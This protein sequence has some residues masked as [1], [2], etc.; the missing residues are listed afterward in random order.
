M[1]AIS[2]ESDGAPDERNTVAL[3]E[4]QL[5]LVREFLLIVSIACGAVAA[6]EL[7]RASQPLPAVTMTLVAF[8]ALLISHRKSPPPKLLL[9]VLLALVLVFTRASIGRG[10]AAASALSLAFLP[11]F[12]GTLVLGPALG[13]LI[14]GAMLLSFAWLGSTTPLESLF[15]RLRF[16][17]E[18]AMTIFAAGLAH[19]LLHSFR[20]YDRAIE[21][22]K[23]ALA[24]LREERHGLTV[25]IYDEL[26][27]ASQ[28]LVRASSD[29]PPGSTSATFDTALARLI[30]SLGR[31]KVLAHPDGTDRSGASDP[32]L[33][34]RLS[35]I[36]VWL[37]LGALLMAFFAVR[38]ALSG[39][40][41][42]PPLTSLCFCVLT[43]FWL[44]SQHAPRN[45][46]ATAFGIG[47]LALGPL[48][49]QVQAY[50]A[51]PSAP[52][53]VIMPGAVLLVVL[54]S[55][56]PAAFVAVAMNGLIL[57]WVGLG[58]PL[59]L[60]EERLLTNL[61]LS[62]VVIFLVVRRVLV[63]RTHYAHTLLTQEASLRRELAQHRR[64]AGTLFHDASNHLQAIALSLDSPA[65]GT[66][67]ERIRSLT[68]R[69]ARLIGLSKHFLLEPGQEP[70]LSAFSLKDAFDLVR[71]AFEPHLESKHIRLTIDGD[72]DTTGDSPPLAW[73][74]PELFVES[75]LGN[76]VS[77]AIKFSP[78][79]TIVAVSADEV[80]DE[81]RVRIRDSGP[82]LPPDV[83]A[84]FASEGSL[85]TRRGTAGESGQGYGLKLAREHVERMGGTLE[86]LS[87]SDG[88]ECVVRLRSARNTNAPMAS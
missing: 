70:R 48:I 16:S 33:A 74:E 14:C 78:E 59:S 20:A 28:E 22:R 83:L 50:G 38:N 75:V 51:T 37:W 68:K 56:G 84:H 66:S 71:E 52:A 6:R 43:D 9:P 57:L 45:L 19:T 12:L 2:G 67:S 77:N 80:G 88:T 55:R 15:D 17:D 54:L 8:A 79:G 81:I 65:T 41:F 31:A 3:E 42:V 63:L 21:A 64:L 76:L 32:D 13:W 82:G 4:M 5:R 26:E 7:F 85:P 24:R 40:S 34:I 47:M 44:R 25:A 53:L 49:A 58:Q 60:L 10:G 73:A 30:E 87:A 46:E 18:V 72:R 29:F 39:I 1:R 62:F 36:R 69:V 35:A 61:F 86:L 27:P 23:E 11:G